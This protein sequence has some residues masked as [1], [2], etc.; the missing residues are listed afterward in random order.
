MNGAPG[1]TRRKVLR[2]VTTYIC[3]HGYGPTIREISDGLGICTSNAWRH[4]HRLVEAGELVKR[5]GLARSLQI[6]TTDDGR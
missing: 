5:E 4:V 3:G 2:F 6:P 1:V